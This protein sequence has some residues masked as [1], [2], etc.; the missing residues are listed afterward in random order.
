[1]SL[2]YFAEQL[3][4][5]FVIHKINYSCYKLYQIDNREM[6]KM[7]IVSSVVISIHDMGAHAFIDIIDVLYMWRGWGEFN[8][9]KGKFDFW[10][11]LV[12]HIRIRIH[13][14]VLFYP[15]HT[16]SSCRGREFEYYKVRSRKAIWFCD[17]YVHNVVISIL[18]HT[19]RWPTSQFKNGRKV[20]VQ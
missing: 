4:I 20:I 18:I 15:I 2:W 7:F 3:N 8:S 11:N 13:M 17:M 14:R 9:K 10:S 16:E 5:S 12:T 19:N 6:A 1:M